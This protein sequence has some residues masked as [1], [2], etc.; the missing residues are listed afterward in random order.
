MSCYFRNIKDI[1]DEAG[2]EVTKENRKQVDEAVHRAVDVAYKNCPVTWKKIKED[3]RGDEEKR[4][5]LIEQ[6][7]VAL[8]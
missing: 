2:I 8:H 4:R 1:L 5:H 6:L 3:I 7:R